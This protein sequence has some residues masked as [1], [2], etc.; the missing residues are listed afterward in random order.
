MAVLQSQWQLNC[1]KIVDKMHVFNVLDLL[2]MQKKPQHMHLW[3]MQSFQEVQR[4]EKKKQKQK[5]GENGNKIS[6][7]KQHS[8]KQLSTHVSF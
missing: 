6:S 4:K 8:V 2:V 1:G 7:S 5:E 3:F